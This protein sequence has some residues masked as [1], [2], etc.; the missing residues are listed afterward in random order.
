MIL[1]R[2]PE[3]DY[4]LVDKVGAQLGFEHRNYKGTFHLRD[5]NLMFDTTD[6]P[7]DFDLLIANDFLE[8]I[9]APSRV[10]LDMRKVIKE[11][12][13][14]FIS[15]PNWRNSH[16]F[17]YR[18]LFDYDNFVFMMQTHGFELEAAGDS[19]LKLVRFRKNITG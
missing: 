15:V 2:N 9:Q 13:L 16:D 12:G 17:I 10:I 4:H 6:I 3:V 7:E 14:A 1:E 18:G 11:N 8:H 19:V 5:M